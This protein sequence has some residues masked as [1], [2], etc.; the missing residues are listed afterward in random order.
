MIVLSSPLLLSLFP[1]PSSSSPLLSHVVLDLLVRPTRPLSKG[2]AAQRLGT[3]GEDTMQG[4]FVSLASW[5]LSLLLS[6]LLLLRG[7]LG[8]LTRKLAVQHRCLGGI[9]SGSGVLQHHGTTRVTMSIGC[10][11]HPH[12]PP[13]SSPK[14]AL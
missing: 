10:P 14:D 4:K 6:L 12:F 11:R 7:S 13:S 2:T 3:P 8:V 9:R 1:S 5:L